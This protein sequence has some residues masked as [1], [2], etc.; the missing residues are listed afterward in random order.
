MA[1]NNVVGQLDAIIAFL[2]SETWHEYWE[3]AAVTAVGFQD[4]GL[5]QNTPDNVIWQTCQAEEIILFTGNRNR[6][7]PDS[8]EEA[9]RL[10]NRADSLP[11]ITLGDPQRFGRERTYADKAAVKLLDYLLNLDRYRGAGR[12]YVP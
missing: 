11:V 8:L 4:V 3:E 10:F 12:L 5:E 7:G 1:D 9:I 2:R 6:Q